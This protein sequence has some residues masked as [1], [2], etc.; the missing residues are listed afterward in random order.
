VAA[1][2]LELFQG[3]QPEVELEISLLGNEAGASEM[4]LVR[5]LPFYSMCTHHLLPFFGH[6][7]IAYVPG[8]QLIG[9]GGIGKVVQHFARRPQ[10][11]ERLTAQLADYLQTALAPQGVIVFLQARQLCMEMRGERTAGV[12]ETT[13]AHGCFQDGPR[14]EE[15]FRRIRGSQ[16][17]AREEER[18]RAR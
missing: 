14:R 13:A 18:E 2:Y 7:H 9:I 6:A 10:L 17:P 15:F 11:Q 4:I 8:R 5:D 3:S 16:I 12:V 1:L